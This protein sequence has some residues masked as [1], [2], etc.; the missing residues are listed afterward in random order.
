MRLGCGSKAIPS[1]QTTNFSM[2][3]TQYI[4]KDG[5]TDVLQNLKGSDVFLAMR[6]SLQTGALADPDI[7]SPSA[8]GRGSV[9]AF[10]QMVVDQLVQTHSSITMSLRRDSPLIVFH[11]VEVRGASLI[12]VRT[13]SSGIFNRLFRNPGP[14]MIA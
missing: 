9:C 2:S 4:M 12:H 13:R 5:I 8:A 1:T 3:C 7:V 11:K 14:M 6:I 10:S